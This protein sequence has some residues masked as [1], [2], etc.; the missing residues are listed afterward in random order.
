MKSTNEST[1]RDVLAQLFN[2]RVYRQPLQEVRVREAWASVAGATVL[3]YT[4]QIRL[5]KTKL[6][7][8][9]ASSPLRQELMYRR[10]ELMA[11]LNELLGEKAVTAIEIY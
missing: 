1:I 5:E 7:V 9:V 4:T 10:G 11:S 3:R 2:G 8:E 6:I